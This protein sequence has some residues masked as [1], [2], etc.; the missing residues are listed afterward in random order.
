MASNAAALGSNTGTWTPARIFLAFSA[1]FHLPVA[2]IGLAIDR[3]FPIG[4]DAAAH[5]GSEH[6]LGILET[7]GWHSLAALIV[8]L[9]SLFYAL[10]PQGARRTALLLGMSHVFVVVGLMLWDPSTFWIAS[11]AADQIVHSSTAIGGI[12]SAL[13][14][15]RETVSGHLD[16]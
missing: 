2:V 5:A 6:I 14:T 7:N 4:A 9:I 1:A 8:G 11:N 12:G 16:G 10:Y 13:L 15:R 3:T